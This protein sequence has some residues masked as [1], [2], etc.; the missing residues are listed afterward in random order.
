MPG[1]RTSCALLTLLTILLAW[2]SPPEALRV[3]VLPC[4]FALLLWFFWTASSGR[5]LLQGQPMRLVCTGF[6]VLWLGFTAAAVV[7]FGE[8]EAYHAA[9]VYVR[10][11]CERGALFLLG[12]TL[13]AYGLMLWIPAQLRA[14][15]VLQ[16][17]LDHQTSELLVAEHARSELEHRL[18]EAD[19]RAILGGIA[20]S[21]A[22]DLRNPLAIVVG[23]A[24][25]LC[26]KQRGPAEIREHTDVIR[27]NID[28]ANQT[29]SALID[30]GRP[31]A[32]APATIDARAVVQ[33]V[34]GL[35]VTE[36]RRRRI[37]FAI[38]VDGRA[39]R[40]GTAPRVFAD[41]TLLQQ[42]LL[43]LVLNAMQATS[44]GGTV[45]LRLRQRRHG[46]NA[47]TVVAVEDRG[48]GIEQ[49]VRMP[50]FAPFHTTKPD[51]TG[52]GLWSCRRIVAELGGRLALYPRHR[53]GA[54]VA[55]LLPA[56]PASAPATTPTAAATTDLE[57]TKPCLGATS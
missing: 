1:A 5:G 35:V 43:N 55:L 25:S 44:S 36:G 12:L 4:Y 21:I 56:A 34:L 41:R 18:V 38:R 14:H 37:A 54:R 29:L 9:F 51:G 30:L 28:K 45:T 7:H 23:T 52:L 13:I 40:A 48:R 31:R 27:R 33:E 6:L 32:S 11:V 2:P 57:E 16:R 42:A 8:L 47:M 10:A 15:E 50:Q 39:G 49:P 24:E 22:H 19:R 53:G 3:I 46:S 20:A 17:D 26:R